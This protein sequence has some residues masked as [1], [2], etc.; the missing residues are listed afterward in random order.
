MNRIKSR[1][2]KRRNKLAMSA[3]KSIELGLDENNAVT[4]SNPLELLRTFDDNLHDASARGD[5]MKWSD[6]IGERGKR[7]SD[8][9]ASVMVA[10]DGEWLPCF[11]KMFAIM[12][13]LRQPSSAVVERVFSQI[14]CI[15]SLCGDNLKQDDL[16]LRATLRCNGN[17][18][19][20]EH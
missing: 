16:E 12:C 13:L 14:N 6:D 3:L 8:W 7:V 19:A 11:E 2:R 18:D 5:V 9:W 10:S 1:H 17:C 15:R 20:C 4:T